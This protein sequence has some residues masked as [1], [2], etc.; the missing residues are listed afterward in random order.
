MEVDEEEVEKQRQRCLRVNEKFLAEHLRTTDMAVNLV[1]EFLPKLPGE[2]PD[3]FL[4]EYAPIKDMSIQQQVGKIAKL[5]GEQMTAQKIG[6]GSA[7]F[8]KEVPMRPRPLEPMDTTESEQPVDEDQLRKDEAKKL[9][10]NMERVKGEQEL[11][12]RMKM[13]AKTLKLQEV[14][15]H[16]LAQL[17]KNFF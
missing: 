14:T 3:H 8:S 15:N 1:V 11:I 2:V 6:P 12:E 13:R 10:E 4:N 5:L 16:F 7:A 9:R 17:R